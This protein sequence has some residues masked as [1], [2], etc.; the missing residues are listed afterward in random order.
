M[1]Q[2][3]AFLNGE[4]IPAA[5]LHIPVYD[6]GF[7]LGATVTEGPRV[8]MHTYRLAL[9][10][11]RRTTTAVAGSSRRQSSKYLQNAGRPS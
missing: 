7:V 2:P 11:G 6:A 5:E 3:L 10:V 1:P 4:F 9:A 8:A